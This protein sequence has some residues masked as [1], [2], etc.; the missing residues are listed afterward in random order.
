M[1][2]YLVMI[3]ICISAIIAISIPSAQTAAANYNS[4][5]PSQTN[6]I[7]SGINVNTYSNRLAYL[8][9]ELSSMY[10][11]LLNKNIFGNGTPVLNAI[12]IAA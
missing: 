9:N 10:S 1:K 6:N 12:S 7:G 5:V 11:N 2:R 3:C 8:K 4:I